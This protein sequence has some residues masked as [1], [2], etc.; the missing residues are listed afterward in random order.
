M[1]LRKTCL[2]FTLALGC[3]ALPASAQE[4]DKAADL[5]ELLD[6]VEQG[7]ETEKEENRQRLAEFE[8]AKDGIGTSAAQHV[9]LCSSSGTDNTTAASSP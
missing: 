6:L 5:F 7:L 9:S 3:A 1:N 2:A 8:N 4:A